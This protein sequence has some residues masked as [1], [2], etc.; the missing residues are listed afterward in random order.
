MV[1]MPCVE[2]T[3][4]DA[5]ELFDRAWLL[6]GRR[7]LLG[8]IRVFGWSS[9]VA[10]PAAHRSLLAGFSCFVLIPLAAWTNP[11]INWGY[12]ATREGFLH[13]ITRGQYEKLQPANPLIRIFCC[14]SRSFFSAWAMSWAGH[15]PCLILTALIT[16]VAD[17]SAPLVCAFW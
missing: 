3:D 12:A 8:V 7:L 13:L 2:S 14:R 16:L 6:R 17:L 5:T 10:C 1:R 9:I 15:V 11:P 4:R